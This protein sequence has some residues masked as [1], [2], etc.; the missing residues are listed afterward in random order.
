MA[1]LSALRTFVY[2][3]YF[4]ALRSLAEDAMRVLSLELSDLN[5]L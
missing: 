3:T 5:A 1:L 4:R 2:T